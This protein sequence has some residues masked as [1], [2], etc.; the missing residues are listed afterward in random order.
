MLMQ[1]KTRQQNGNCRIQRA[2]HNSHIQPPDLRGANEGHAPTNVENA[3][4]HSNPQ[5]GSRHGMEV[6]SE[7]D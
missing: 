3:R 7:Q 6:P 4:R 5:Y 2:Q 1:K